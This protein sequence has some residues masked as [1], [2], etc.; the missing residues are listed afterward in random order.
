MKILNLTPNLSF[1][2]PELVTKFKNA[3][4]LTISPLNSELENE[5]HIKCEIGSMSYALALIV[6]GF[7]KDS[8]IEELDTGFLSGESNVGEEEIE[9]ILEFLDGANLVI[10]DEEILN[11]NKDSLNLKFLIN[12]IASNFS[13]EIVSLNGDKVTLKNTKFSELEELD[14]FDGAVVF[15]H[16]KD[17][18]FVGGNYFCLVAKIKDGDKVRIKAPNLDV[19]REFKLDKEMRG[20]VALLGVDKV[21]SY[22]YEVVK[23]SKV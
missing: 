23:V 11:H 5:T 18:K 7:S 17:D 20:T 9:D 2:A 22:A 15:K 10:V 4:F 12:A 3:E 19:V 21:D 1:Q 8:A 6:Q 14:S 16:T 13:L